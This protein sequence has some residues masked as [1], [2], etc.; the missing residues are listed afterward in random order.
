MKNRDDVDINV[1]F[2]LMKNPL[3][4][5]Q[6]MAITADAFNIYY[7]QDACEQVQLAALHSPTSTSH[8]IACIHNP[9]ENVKREAFN[10]RRYCFPHIPNPPEDIL[11]PAVEYNGLN[12]QYIPRKRQTQKLILAAVRE[13]P[14]AMD[15]IKIKPSKN[16]LAEFVLLSMK[17]EI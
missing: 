16:T 2:P 14:M 11:L 1:S 12:L 5:T 9:T 6:L 7:I 8:T 15:Y 4:E 13:N 17:G 3:L 10:K